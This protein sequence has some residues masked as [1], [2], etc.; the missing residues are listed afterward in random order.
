MNR[1]TH[2]LASSVALM[3]AAGVEHAQQGQ[4]SPTPYVAPHVPPAA[5]AIEQ[6]SNGNQPGVVL[7]E[8]FDGIGLGFTGPQ[9]VARVGNP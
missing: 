3:L 4:P 9:G 8:S 7:V 1:M 6:T 5:A 2:A